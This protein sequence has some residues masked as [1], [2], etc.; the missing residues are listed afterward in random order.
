[1]AEHGHV[2]GAVADAGAHH[3]SALAE[4]ANPTAPHVVANIIACAEL[5]AKCETARRSDVDLEVLIRLEGR[6]E[7]AERKLNLKAAGPAPALTLSDYLAS[8]ELRA[9]LPPDAGAAEDD[10][11][12]D[13][14]DE[15]AGALGEPAHAPSGA[16]RD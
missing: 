1:V 6:A 3:T 12:D 5:K 11:E 15:P 8:P 4:A 14:E 10:P 16:R 7:R 13:P 9:S 2:F